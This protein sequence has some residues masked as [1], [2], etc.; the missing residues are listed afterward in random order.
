MFACAARVH[1]FPAGRVLYPRDACHPFCEG[2]Q[3]VYVCLVEQGTDVQCTFAQQSP[4]IALHR[5][6]HTQSLP[7]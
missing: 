6:H 1:L 3:I 4:A 7:R 2:M 5:R